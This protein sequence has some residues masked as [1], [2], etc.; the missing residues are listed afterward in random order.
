MMVID[1]SIHYGCVAY[2][3]VSKS[4]DLSIFL[5]WIV[6]PSQYLHLTQDQMLVLYNWSTKICTSVTG[7]TQMVALD[8]F[9]KKKLPFI[10]IYES[11]SQIK[12]RCTTLVITTWTSYSLVGVV[13]LIMIIGSPS[14][15]DSFSYS[16]SWRI[17]S[18]ASCC[19]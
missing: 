19:L 16:L 4:W 14:S 8:G 12:L 18:N 11:S 1:I 15:F 5:T 2:H 3:L 10:I 13:L 9:T 17:Y 6:V 7:Q